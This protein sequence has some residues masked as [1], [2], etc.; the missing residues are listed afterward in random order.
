M[1]RSEMA[2]IDA[3]G[4]LGL[5]GIY[6][7]LPLEYDKVTRRGTIFGPKPTAIAS[8]CV[9]PADDLAATAGAPESDL[10]PSSGP[11]FTPIRGM[12]LQRSADPAL[13]LNLLD[14]FAP[15]PSPDKRPSNS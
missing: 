10:L 15:S 12:G 4:G 6:N 7:V 11:A 5:A 3:K 8:L 13:R 9:K 1:C 2:E 14:I